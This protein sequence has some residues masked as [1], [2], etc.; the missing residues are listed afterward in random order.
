MNKHGRPWALVL[1]GGGA[2]GLAHI[3]VLKGLE[4][5]GFEKPSLVVGTSMGAII[6]GLYACGM[7]PGEMEHFIIEEFNITD[8]LDSF[9]FRINGKVGKLIQTGQI[10]ASLAT[11]TGIDKGQR[12]LK[13][14]ESLTGG[15]NFNETK[16]PFR[17]NAADLLSGRE[18]V[19]S[20]GSVA[21][22]MRASMSI[23][24]FFE[25]FAEG[26]MCLVDG[27]LLDNMPVH[28]AR[29]EGYRRV[30]AINVNHLDSQESR[31]LRSGPQ[32]IY[33]SLECALHSQELK[34]E[35]A[36]L[37]FNVSDEATP[38]SFFRQRELIELGERTVKANLKALET[39]SRPRFGFFGR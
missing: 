15:K 1:S 26:G 8:Y 39:F 13:L 10:L 22:A 24:V 2:R 16:I 34:R 11:Q 36:D 32:I 28:I 29:E 23:P 18:V 30:L 37:T 33:R 19:F 14:L 3:G 21:R 6:G 31:D 7:T 20:S 35:S 12:V 17:C 38:F 5:A 4:A 9:V 27:G 25:P